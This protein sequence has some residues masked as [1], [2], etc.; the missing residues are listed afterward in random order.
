M[1]DI[2]PVVGGVLWAFDQLGTPD[3]ARD[4]RLLA[5]AQGAGYRQDSLLR[6]VGV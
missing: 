1:R 6:I 4:Q 5:A 3:R 2:L